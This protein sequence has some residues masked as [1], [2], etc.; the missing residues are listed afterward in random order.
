[1][2]NASGP[3]ER[4]KMFQPSRSYQAFGGRK[5]FE[6]KRELSS[7][8]LSKKA[9]GDKRQGGGGGEPR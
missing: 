5:S 9:S 3:K 2:I 8:P 1:M 4:A 7:I 6:F